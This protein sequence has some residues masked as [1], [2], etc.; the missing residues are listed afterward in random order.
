MADMHTHT[1]V[2]SIVAALVVVTGI[3]G[4]AQSKRVPVSP[5]AAKPQTIVFVC[6]FGSAKSVVAAR[7]FNRMATEKGLPYRAVARG[8]TPEATI[9][10]YVR[11][12]IRADGFEIGAAE[13]PVRLKAAEVRDASAVVCIMCQLPQEHSTVARQSIEWSDVPDVDAGYG[14]ARDKIVAHLNE[15]VGTLRPF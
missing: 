10:P 4:L 1:R 9:P 12:P 11:Q 13:K 15:L 7:F 3:V 8:L 2:A 14:P 5:P 6:P